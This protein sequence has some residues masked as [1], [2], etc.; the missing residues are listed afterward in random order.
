MA[1]HTVNGGCPVC[2]GDVKGDDDHLYHCS[3]CNLL[4]AKHSLKTT[5]IR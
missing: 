2:G 5:Q 1:I 4:F 3:K